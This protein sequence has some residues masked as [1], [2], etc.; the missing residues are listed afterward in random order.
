MSKV[1]ALPAQP[2]LWP[3]IPGKAHGL[4]CLDPVTVQCDVCGKRDTWETVGLTEGASVTRV[5][6]ASGIK[7]WG[8]RQQDQRRLC[9]DCAGAGG[10]EV[11][12]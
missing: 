4:V 1:Y 3:D 2:D 9:R 12:S 11:R 5:V 8:M 10:Y 6:M 7:F